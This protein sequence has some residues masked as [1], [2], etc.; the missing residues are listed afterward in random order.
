M[1]SCRSIELDACAPPLI[2]FI[3]G[4]GNVVARL[5]A[6]VPVERHARLGS[7]GLRR[8]E[9]DAEDRVRAEPALVR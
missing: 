7:R 3:I 8:G 6:E 4:T 1:N 2:T 9:G 5:A